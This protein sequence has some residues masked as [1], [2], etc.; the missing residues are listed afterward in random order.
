MYKPTMLRD[1]IPYLRNIRQCGGET[2]AACPICE[3]GSSNGHHLYVR[4][5]E[6]T[7]LAYCQKCNAKLPEILKALGVKPE[8]IKTEKPEKVEEC[9]Y[10]YRN[11]DSTAAYYKHRVKYADGRKSFRFWYVDENGKGG[12]H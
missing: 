5:S 1:I 12:D 4:E 6:G 8:R 2:V 3:A 7:L 11:P 10:A 9:D